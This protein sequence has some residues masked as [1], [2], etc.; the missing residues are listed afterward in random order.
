MYILA[1]ALVP[2]GSPPHMVSGWEIVIDQKDKH[3]SWE[4]LWD[5]WEETFARALLYPPEYLSGHPQ[6]FDREI[7][8][9]ADLH[10]LE[11]EE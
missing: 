10:S 2:P 5:T 1:N 3:G 4:P 8:E 11:F 9:P 6:W 7:N